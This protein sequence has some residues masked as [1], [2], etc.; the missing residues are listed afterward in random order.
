[1]ISEFCIYLSMLP[2]LIKI[3]T[4]IFLLAIC[5]IIIGLLIIVSILSKKSE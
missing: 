2:K 1:M 4:I 5:A 3:K